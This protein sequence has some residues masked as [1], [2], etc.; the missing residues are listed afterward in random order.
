MTALLA[1]FKKN[2]NK[3]YVD[4]GIFE[5]LFNFLNI[6]FNVLNYFR[7][8]KIYNCFDSSNIFM[9]V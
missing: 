9:P 3:K 6:F 8:Y 2:N 5:F 1:Y 7:F 4:F